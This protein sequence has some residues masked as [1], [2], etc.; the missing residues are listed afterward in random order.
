[1]GTR[2]RRKDEEEEDDDNKEEA[3]RGARGV[4]GAAPAVGCGGS[5]AIVD[6]ARRRHRHVRKGAETEG[7]AGPGQDTTGHGASG[8]RSGKRARADQVLYTAVLRSV[9]LCS[10]VLLDITLQQTKFK[11]LGV[12]RPIA[13]RGQL[14]GNLCLSHP[15][16]LP[17]PP[18]LARATWEALLG[19][20]GRSTPPP[21][22]FF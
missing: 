20:R 18:W 13:F 3:W 14:P 21:I 12:R 8:G 19:S 4:V 7:K 11:Q 9:E 22:A 1:M 6:T 5:A 16:S 15:P 10:A 17:P 2:R